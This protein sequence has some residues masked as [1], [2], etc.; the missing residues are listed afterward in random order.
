MSTKVTR[1]QKRSGSTAT[2][3][4]QKIFPFLACKTFSDITERA[5][6]LSLAISGVTTQ[7]TRISE[8]LCLWLLT[9]LLKVI[10]G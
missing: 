7:Q 6:A 5:L 4:Q 9:W 3:Q 10:I 1:E 8:S 2:E